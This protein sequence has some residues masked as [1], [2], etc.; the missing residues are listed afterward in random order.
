VGPAQKVQRKKAK[1]Q[2][3]KKCKITKAQQEM[4]Y[5]WLRMKKKG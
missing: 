3:R 5:K 1:A 4:D 2:N